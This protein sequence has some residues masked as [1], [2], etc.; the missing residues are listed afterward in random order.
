MVGQAVKAQVKDNILMAMVQFI[1]QD[2]MRIMEQVIT[3]EFVKVNMEEIATLPA[4]IKNSTNE[5]NAYIIQLFLY[6]KRNLKDGTKEGYLNA[7]KRLLLLIDKPLPAIDDTDI[8]YYLNW[9]EKRNININGKRNQ[10]TTVNN[11]R[12]FLSAFFTWMRKEKLRLDNPVEITQPKKV[13][14]KP[15]DY[16]TKEE[17]AKLRDACKTPRDRALIEV[18]RSTGARVGEIVSI[19][20]DM[21]DWSTGDIMICGEKGDRYRPIYLD[22]DA[23]YYLKKYIDQR[24]DT[25]NSIFVHDRGACDTLQPCGIRVAMKQ[26]AKRAGVECRVYP[27]KMRKTL[28]MDLKNKGVD[29]GTIQEIMGHANPAV[30]AMYYAQSTPGTLRNVRERTAA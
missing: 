18:F 17:M 26:I 2:I 25:N 3:Q 16:Y 21:I 29:I 7:V 24:T 1:N 14:K 12:R 10:G 11:E 20:L 15:I 30:T 8:S 13:P 5:Q 28:G 4:E 23:R 27:H 9:Y 19:T 22:A 6:K